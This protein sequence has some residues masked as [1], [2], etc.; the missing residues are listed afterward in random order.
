M[1]RRITE[2]EKVCK[3][4]DFRRF[5]LQK[6]DRITTMG[7]A[8]L[9]SYFSLDLSAHNHALVFISIFILHHH[10]KQGRK[11]MLDHSEHNDDNKGSLKHK[12]DERHRRSCCH[13]MARCCIFS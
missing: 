6:S 8:G 13:F 10:I 9:F 5:S 1:K 12:N 4:I 2:D 7:R 3:L 11:S